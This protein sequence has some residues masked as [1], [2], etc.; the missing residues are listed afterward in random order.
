[1]MTMIQYT[2]IASRSE[3]VS[4]LIKLMILVFI[5]LGTGYVAASK[6]AQ[7]V[8]RSAQTCLRL[9]RQRIKDHI[10][11]IGHAYGAVPVAASYDSGIEMEAAGEDG[12]KKVRKGP[13]NVQ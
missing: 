12:C 6:Y 11:I 2:A 8:N 4:S 10:K 13:D 1:M 9:P 3:A 5:S 7:T